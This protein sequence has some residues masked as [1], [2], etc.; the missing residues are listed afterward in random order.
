MERNQPSKGCSHPGDGRGRDESGYGKKEWGALTS[1]RWQRGGQV[2]TWKESDQVRGTHILEMA[3]G[4]GSG[5]IKK[6]TE[7]GALTSLR[8]QRN[9]K[10]RT[11]KESD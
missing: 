3:E 1:W 4:D 6:A 5:H 10:F 7:Q 8:Q 11:Q 9:G 2:R